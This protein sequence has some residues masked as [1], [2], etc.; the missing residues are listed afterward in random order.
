MS[1]MWEEFGI[2]N[3]EFGIGDR[4]PP[5]PQLS[6]LPCLPCPNFECVNFEF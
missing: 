4:S 6:F 5:L 2:R 3:S 1:M